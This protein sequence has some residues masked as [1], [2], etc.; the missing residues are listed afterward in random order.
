MYLSKK[1]HILSKTLVIA[2]LIPIA[3]TLIKFVLRYLMRGN[4]GN[5]L[6]DMLDQGIWNMQLAVD[7]SVIILTVI[8]FVIANRKIKKSISVIDDDDRKMLGRLQEDEF[9]DNLST[10]SAE[11]IYNLINV[12]A[13]V[14]ILIRTLG[15]IS[16]IIYKNFAEALFKLYTSGLVHKKKALVSIYDETHHFKYLALICGII[17][18][19]MVTAIILRDR[20]LK[21]AVV[22]VTVMFI[23]SFTVVEMTTFEIF[24]D[25]IGVVWSSVLAHIVE[26]IAMF[27][28]AVYL[29][30]RYRGI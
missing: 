3:G 30:K 5:G 16:S 24:E 9:G 1:S 13:T 26:T 20:I 12:W 21:I 18:G 22:I 2:T 4:G 8:A 27:A 28:F 17:L 19:V 25:K 6:P 10:L 29:R 7:V 11:T 23:F 14:F 15:E